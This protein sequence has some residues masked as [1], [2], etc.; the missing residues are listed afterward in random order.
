MQLA[1]N[2]MTDLQ[3]HE[4]LSMIFSFLFFPIMIEHPADNYAKIIR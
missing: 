4:N 1:T 3:V 2:L